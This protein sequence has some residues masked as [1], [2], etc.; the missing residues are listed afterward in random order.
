MK[1]QLIPSRSCP[2]RLPY[3]L[4]FLP[5]C[6]KDRS[7]LALQ[8]ELQLCPLLVLDSK[9]PGYGGIPTEYARFTIDYNLAGNPTDML[10]AA[11]SEPNPIDYHFRY[12]HFNRLTDYVLTYHPNVGGIIWHRYGYPD[13]QTVTDT[14]YDYVGNITSPEPPHSSFDTYLNIIKLDELGRIIKIFPVNLA[15]GSLGAPQTFAYDARGNMIRA[16]VVYD[17][18]INPYQTNPVWMFVFNDYSINNPSADLYSVGP[19]TIP[20]FNPIGLPLEIDG[21]VY[22]FDQ[23]L[24]GNLQLEYACDSL[25]ENSKGR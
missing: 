4:Y 10:F 23:T 8:R 16:G 18:K 14:S 3:F 7:E 20:A 1:W 17:N 21:D 5:A 6:V 11:G 2:G 15:D 12:D 25:P 13:R 24:G 9:Y 19:V 22:L